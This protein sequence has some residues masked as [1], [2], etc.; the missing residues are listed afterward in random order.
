MVDFPFGAWAPDQGEVGGLQVAD[1]VLPLADGY[2][3][4]PSLYVSPTA[5]ALPGDPKGLISVVLNDDSFQAFGFIQ[6]AVYQLNGDFT[7]TLVQAGFTGPSG[8][9]D[10][11]PL[12][13]G[14]HLLFTNI[15]DGLQDYDLESPGSVTYIAGAGDPEFIFT[16]GNFIIALNCLDATGTRDIRLIKTTGFNDQT[17]WTSDG[18]DYQ[19]LADGEAL[20]AGF[21]LKNRNALLLQR[22]ALVLM[23][24]GSAPAGAQFSLAKVADGKGTVGSRSCVGFDGVVFYWSDDGPYRFDLNNGNVP[25]GDDA[26]VEWFSAQVDNSRLDLIRGA[27]DPIRKIVRWAFK[28]SVDNSDTVAEV[29]ICYHWQRK[30]WFTLT[31]QVASLCR[32]A[33]VAV[34]YNT[35]TG[36]YD[37]QTLTYDDRLFLGSAPL[38]GALDGSYKF[39]AS[40]GPNLAGTIT[41]QVANNPV[42]GLVNWATPIDD[43]ATGTLELGVKDRLDDAITFKP[44]A[45]KIRNGAVPLRGRGMNLQFR[46]NFPGAATWSYAKGI[47]HL[48]SVGGGPK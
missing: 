12:H 5:A 8:D 16:C 45:S 36:T 14:D 31:E 40:T 23:T 28:R 35:I 19:E 7:W 26:I 10:W 33:S 2:G 9:G 30:K 24:F 44:A 6:G 39:G 15:N 1:G 22:R 27:V 42:T 48:S 3:P 43:C 41:T 25:I 46:R 38:A 17:N 13:F 32:L 37:S 11:S 20:K 21:D 34:S 47:D 4:F 18:A 29:S